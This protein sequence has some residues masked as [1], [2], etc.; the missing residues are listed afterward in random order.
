[1]HHPQRQFVY[2][3]EHKHAQQYIHIHLMF[4]ENVFVCPCVVVCLRM[5]A[6]YAA[7]TFICM[8]NSSL[9]RGSQ[10]QHQQQQRQHGNVEM[11][12]HGT[13]VKHY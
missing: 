12:I 5:S 11:K 8:N 1:M 7:S 2:P 9:A 3:H 10:H 13:L 4:C 6:C